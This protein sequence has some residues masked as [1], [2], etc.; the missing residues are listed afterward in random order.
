MTPLPTPHPWIR[1]WECGNVLRME[2]PK[3]F[4]KLSALCS[5]S[6]SLGSVSESKL[7]TA[8]S[9]KLRTNLFQIL[10]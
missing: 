10:T 8:I 1:H 7:W 5:L 3:M 9:P 4:Q 2:S 6:P